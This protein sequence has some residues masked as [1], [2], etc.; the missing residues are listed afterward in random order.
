MEHIAA[1]LL[2]IGCSDDLAQCR[3]LPAPVPVFETAQECEAEL[4]NAFKAYV[5]D[6][7]QI[8]AQCV[9]VDPALEEE[10]AELVWDI[11]EDGTLIAEIGIPEVMVA[12]REGKQDRLAPSQF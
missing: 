3:E 9:P 7:P 4:V 5:N 12:G 11:R 6:F 2:V 10:D 1:L 8:F